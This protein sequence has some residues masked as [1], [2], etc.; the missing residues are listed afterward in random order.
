MLNL[1]LTTLT[2]AMKEFDKAHSAVL[3]FVRLRGGDAAKEALVDVKLHEAVVEAEEAA[4]DVIE[5]RRLPTIGPDQETVNKRIVDT[6]ILERDA[7]YD[8]AK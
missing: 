2:K 6:A 4:E 5:V 1:K 7:A 3:E 8:R